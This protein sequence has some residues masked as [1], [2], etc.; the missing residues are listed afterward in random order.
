MLAV[1]FFLS[2]CRQINGLSLSDLEYNDQKQAGQ[3]K[4]MMIND[5]KMI[6]AFFDELSANCQNSFHFAI[7]RGA[8][9]KDARSRWVIICG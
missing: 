2:E 8:Q 4:V 5:G 7:I 6:R 9:Q 3:M 1:I